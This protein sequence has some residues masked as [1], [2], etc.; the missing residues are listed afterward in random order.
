MC[1][2][3]GIFIQGHMPVMLS[4]HTPLFLVTLAIAFGSYE[5]YTNKVV[6]YMHMNTLAYVAYIW[7]LRGILNFCTHVSNMFPIT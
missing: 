1:D 7:H 4:V 5:A 3:E 6:S 2:V